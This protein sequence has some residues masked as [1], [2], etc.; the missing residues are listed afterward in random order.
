MVK[1]AM[2]KKIKKDSSPKNF[3]DFLHNNEKD[4]ERDELK[5]TVSKKTK[6]IVEK[7]I[8]KN[9]LET[10]KKPVTILKEKKRIIKKVNVK[11]EDVFS[12]SDFK[13]NP[14]KEVFLEIDKKSQENFNEKKEKED[15]SALIKQIEKDLNSEIELLLAE[16]SS[17][18]FE[19]KKV[20]S[21]KKKNSL[22]VFIADFSE[23]EKKM[24]LWVMVFLFMTVFSSFWAI[25]L[26]S[27]VKETKL[28]I[29]SDW[30]TREDIAK[31]RIEIKDTFDNLKKSL[32]NF[33]KEV[34][35]NETQNF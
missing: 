31:A 8:K 22:A 7:K 25:S 33:S 13:I 3:F 14:E 9:F 20:S 6:K 17:L 28:S 5:K 27:S 29:N 1:K 19:E 34:N 4:N 16:R 21:K 2:T 26:M 15:N 10:K 24:L 35:I 12:D 23:K 18:S 30:K 11:K 32:N